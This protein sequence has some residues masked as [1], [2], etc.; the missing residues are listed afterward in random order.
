MDRPD[1]VAAFALAAL[2]GGAAGLRI[3][4]LANI[5]AVRAVTRAPII[6]L[7][8]RDLADS[9]VRITPFLEDVRGL[10]QAGADVIAFDATDRVRPAARE[11]IVSEIHALGRIAMADCSTPEDGRA[12]RAMGV[13]ILGSTLSG[14]T[15]GEVPAAPD[16]ELVDVLAGLDAFVV[17]EG[18]YHVPEQAAL[19][20]RHGADAVVV[21]S[22]ITR[23]EH[24]TEWFAR[25]IR[26]AGTDRS[27][28][29][30]V[31][32]VDLGGSKILAA[33]VKGREVI[34]RAEIPTEAAAGPEA[35]LRQ[36]A[37]LSKPWAGHFT[38]AGLSVTGLVAGGRW[39]ALNPATLNMAG[40]FD[41]KARAEALLGVPAV[42]A[43][44]AQAAAWGE[45]AF[46]AGEGADIVFLTISTG[47]G[48]GVVAGGRLMRGRVGLAGHFGQLRPWSG[49]QR[50][51]FE[52]EASG[53]WI[54]SEAA[55]I[56]LPADARAVFTAAAE[57]SAEA[58]AIIAL[59]ADRVASL[60]Q[61]LQLT[62]DPHRIV[63]GGG[64]GLAPG[65]LDRVARAL[66]Y[67]DPMMRPE[68]VAARLGRDAGIIG[69][70]DLALQKT[71]HWEKTQ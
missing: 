15:G 24:V 62:F 29:R 16:L 13:E 28:P 71:N 39:R 48:G 5:R 50:E 47:V 42:L 57:G 10:A 67:L 58:D 37:G 23:T 68:L 65:Y 45:H 9:P 41:L 51:R 18:R 8:K 34:A 43:N 11:E 40:D 49:E 4:G 59:S 44:D 56:G 6:G 63:I 19:A 17:A 33:L 14:Y 2:A 69:M 66:A 25:S 30:P 21:G 36:I 60:C 38:H 53:R 27:A 52:D 3:E 64:V 35:W 54:A 61:D 7:I 20:K 1:T 70:A 31:L 46:G 26:S 55:R 32:S 12:A 22:A